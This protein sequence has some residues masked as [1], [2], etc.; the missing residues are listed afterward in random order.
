MLWLVIRALVPFQLFRPN[1]G[2]TIGRKHWGK[3][4]R[5]TCSKKLERHQA[6]SAGRHSLI[7]RDW[8]GALE[9]PHPLKY[10]TPKGAPPAIRDAKRAQ[11]RTKKR[12]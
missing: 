5:G 7:V 10:Q 12:A 2:P 4:F 6:A 3:H 11:K 1:N 9:R 8:L